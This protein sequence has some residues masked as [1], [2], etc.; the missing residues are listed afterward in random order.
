MK[1]KKKL[2]FIIRLLPKIIRPSYYKNITS[3]FNRGLSRN[4]I[5]D[6]LYK[7]F[8]F[9]LPF[10]LIKHR[11]FFSTN[12][13]GFGEDSFHSM[14][15]L[16]FSEFK[17]KN[18]LEIGVYRGQ[19]ITLWLL[20]SKQLKYDL[21]SAGLAPFVSGNDSDSKY[22]DSINYLDDTKKN[23]E[24]FNLKQSEYCVEYSTSKNAKKFIESKKW[25]VIFIDGNHDGFILFIQVSNCTDDHGIFCLVTF[26]KK[27]KCIKA[28]FFINR[29]RNYPC[30]WPPY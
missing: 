3:I 7:Y 23:H 1:F 27:G 5:Y 14:W 18:C 15:Y 28:P 9:H 17:P 6:N 2:K 8:Y 29:G 30:S 13:R 26:Y 22:S 25:D 20:I 21:N 11:I 16:L 24:Y 12:S 10:A 19:I 4:E